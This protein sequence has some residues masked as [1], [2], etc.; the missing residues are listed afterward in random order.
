LADLLGR[1]IEEYEKHHPSV[2]GAEVRDALRMAAVSSKAAAPAPAL[3]AGLVVLLLAGLVVFF[4]Q[5]GF[6]FGGDVTLRGAAL[7]S[8]SILAV[9]VLIKRLVGR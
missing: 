5:E 7:V 3:V 1:V 8:L 4:V 6:R 2:T 9:A